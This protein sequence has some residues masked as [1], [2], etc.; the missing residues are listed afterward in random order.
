M[1]RQTI[2]K[3]CTISKIFE[4][5]VY[6]HVVALFIGQPHGSNHVS[7]GDLRYCKPRCSGVMHH[8]ITLLRKLWGNDKDTS[9]AG[10]VFV[11]FSS[12]A[13]VQ[14][15]VTILISGQYKQKRQTV[16]R[17]ACLN[18]ANYTVLLP[19]T[20]YSFISHTSME[21]KM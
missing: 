3:V 19:L 21:Y 9:F 6:L 15:C 7:G 11:N 18:F 20:Q 2:P 14:S 8:N 16:H 12:T 4:I 13:L 10:C 1:L 17:T 5:P